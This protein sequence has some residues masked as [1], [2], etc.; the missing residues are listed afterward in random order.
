M[1]YVPA[2]GFGGKLDDVTSGTVNIGHVIDFNFNIDIAEVDVTHQQSDT[3]APFYK[4]FIPGAVSVE[5]T[6][7]CNWDPGATE[8]EA[9]VLDNLGAER[10]F[11]Y[12]FKDGTTWAFSGFYRSPSIA[13]PNED[14][15]TA[16]VGIRITGTP[17]FTG[18]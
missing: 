17:T 7:T 9:C 11:Q 2:I 10:D 1:A 16:D 12:T 6:F 5:A 13:V 4:E 18:A 14:K 8:H 15:L 3:S